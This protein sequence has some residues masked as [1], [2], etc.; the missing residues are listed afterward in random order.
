MATL[1]TV[2]FGDPLY[3]L[4]MERG[5]IYGSVDVGHLVI[6]V[7][8]AAIFVAVALRAN[9][10][11]PI[12]LAAFQLVSV[13]SHFARE[14]TASFPKLAYGL[15]TYIPF[16]VILLI[17]AGGLVFHARR[18]KYLG[19]YRSWRTSSSPSRAAPRTPQPTA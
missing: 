14:V 18:T 10:V 5:A 8:V 16:Y 17:M 4:L 13:L 11:Y 3:H 2:T 19:R 1:F 12:W 6:D 15:M 9:R 7:G